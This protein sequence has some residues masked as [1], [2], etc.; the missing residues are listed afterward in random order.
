MT[1]TAPA[2]LRRTDD[3]ARLLNDIDA[4]NIL[5]HKGW[6][7]HALGETT[8][9]SKTAALLLKEFVAHGLIAV[10]EKGSPKQVFLTLEGKLTKAR[11]TR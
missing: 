1:N 11:W 5:W 2:A 3:R 7:Q 8:L 10:T 6:R 9:V 4:G